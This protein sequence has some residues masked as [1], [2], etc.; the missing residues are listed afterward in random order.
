MK[1][2]C[3]VPTE[4]ALLAF[5]HT[6]TGTM[7]DY[8]APSMDVTPSVYDIWKLGHAN[9]LSVSAGRR[10]VDCTPTFAALQ[11]GVLLRFEE[12]RLPRSDIVNA[13]KSPNVYKNYEEWCLLGCY[14]VKTSNLTC[15]KIVHN[16]ISC[17]Q[18]DNVIDISHK[19]LHEFLRSPWV[20]SLNACRAKRIR[21]T[22]TDTA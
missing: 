10:N 18:S 17:L 2:P 11:C 1:A 4:C 8:R 15:I 21:S 7:A 12:C 13:V 6:D 9:A 3:S 16:L 14:A 19:D 20:N 22:L 5:G